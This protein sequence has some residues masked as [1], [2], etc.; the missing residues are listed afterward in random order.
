MRSLHGCRA[1]NWILEEGRWLWVFWDA[2][3]ERFFFL[4]FA[5]GSDVSKLNFLDE[6]KKIREGKDL[7]KDNCFNTI[8]FSKK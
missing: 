3:I 8:L 1:I 4:F 2:E 7:F 5:W 6:E